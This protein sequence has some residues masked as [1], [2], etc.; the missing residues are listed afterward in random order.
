MLYCSV[1][2]RSNATFIV[3][4]LLRAKKCMRGMKYVNLRRN[5]LETAQDYTIFP[6]L[7]LQIPEV[8]DNGI[9]N[10]YQ[11]GNKIYVMSDNC[12]FRNIDPRSLETGEKYDG[13][14][15][16]GV[17]GLT[18][19]PLTDVHGDTYNIGFS[20][21]SGIKFHL[22]K[23]SSEAKSISN[24]KDLL[25]RH[26]EIIATIPSSFNGGVAFVHSFGMT[27]EHII[28]IEQPYIAIVSAI[29]MT[30]IKGYSIKD[31]M[32]WK[33]N[34]RNKFHI[35]EKKTGKVIKTEYTSASPFF[36]LHVVNSFHDRKTDQVEISLKRPNTYVWTSL[37]MFHVKWVKLLI[38]CV[39]YVCVCE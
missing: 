18:A 8:T 7:S 20:I 1:S 10:I 22:V 17:N 21:L 30:L 34:L 28:F 27:E 39:C 23:I 24:S 3:Q 5:D 4:A 32:E 2:V 29:P 15:I 35:I 37:C 26:S 19:H 6:F 11:M 25:A 16:F 38:L 31:W 12:F 33:P 9:G 13:N 14:K 36:F